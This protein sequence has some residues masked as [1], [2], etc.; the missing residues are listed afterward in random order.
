[1]L[2]RR[3]PF[4]PLILAVAFVFVACGS[5]AGDDPTCLHSPTGQANSLFMSERFPELLLR[6]EEVLFNQTQVI[7]PILTWNDRQPLLD[8]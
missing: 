7:L 2:L 3:L 8:T 4:S 6:P 5:H 1:M